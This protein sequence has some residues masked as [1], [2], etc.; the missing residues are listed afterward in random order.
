MPALVGRY[1]DAV[2]VLLDGRGDD[3]INRSVVAEMDHFDASGQQQAPHEVD[4]RVGAVENARCCYEADLVL[5]TI[6]CRRMLGSN[7]GCCNVHAASPTQSISGKRIPRLMMSVTLKRRERN[8][9]I[10]IKTADVC[11]P[12]MAC[13]TACRPVLHGDGIRLLSFLAFDRLPLA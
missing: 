11:R 13:R 8:A 3:L 1:G 6:E 2:H 5:W 9:L 12:L 4:R 10:W 7:E